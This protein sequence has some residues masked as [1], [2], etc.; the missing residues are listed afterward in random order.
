MPHVVLT[1]APGISVPTPQSKP[2]DLAASRGLRMD[3]Q[4]SFADL[5]LPA[6]TF[7]KFLITHRFYNGHQ[8]SAHLENSLLK[9]IR[10][11]PVLPY[12]RCPQSLT[13][14]ARERNPV[15]GGN[16]YLWDNEAHVAQTFPGPQSISTALYPL[17]SRDALSS[18]NCWI[19]LKSCSKPRLAEAKCLFLFPV[20]N[21]AGRV[22]QG[23][24]PRTGLPGRESRC[25]RASGEATHGTAGAGVSVPLLTMTLGMFL[26][27]Q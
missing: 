15:A 17:F 6:T 22:L 1:F 4:S 2:R 12:G 18:V 14:A 25:R 24:R 9:I 21:A 26:T 5:L 11:T 20:G 7:L 3:R 10:L 8:T 23:R 16:V 13:G 19:S 27:L